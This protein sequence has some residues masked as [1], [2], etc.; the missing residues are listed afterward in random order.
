[1][2]SVDEAI[3]RRMHIVPFTV[4]IPEENRIRGFV[5]QLKPE[6]PQILY[7]MIQ[8]CAAWRD[9]GL[10]PPEKIRD[11]TD[12]YLTNED[13]LGAW[14]EECCERDGISDGKTLYANFSTWCEDQ[15]ERPWSRR[16]WSNAM[17][18]R[19]FIPTRSR[20]SRGFLGVRLTKDGKIGD[21]DHLSASQRY[22]TDQ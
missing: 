17:L 9:Y 12:Q 16:A 10:A 21:A 11:A 14:L 7:W 6:W 19:G 15:G 8:G 3:K 5:D 13:H 22:Y 1:M 2:R 20:H 18:D 4:T